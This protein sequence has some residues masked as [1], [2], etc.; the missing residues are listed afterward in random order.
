MKIFPK[1]RFVLPPVQGYS[2]HRRGCWV[3]RN[4][5]GDASLSLR[6]GSLPM[7]KCEPRSIGPIGN[8]GEGDG[9]QTY[10]IFAAVSVP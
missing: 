7:Y 6:G 9:K 4:Y 10:K 1:T 5:V 2:L 3:D 8:R